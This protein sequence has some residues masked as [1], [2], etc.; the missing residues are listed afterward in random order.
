MR[1]MVEVMTEY[2][3]WISDKDLFWLLKDEEWVQPSTLKLLLENEE[4]DVDDRGLSN[5]GRHLLKR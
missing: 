1:R 4:G 5:R 3:S 2:V